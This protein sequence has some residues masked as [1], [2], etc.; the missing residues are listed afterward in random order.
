MSR[1]FHRPLR[2]ATVGLC[3]A[4]VGL[5]ALAGVLAFARVGPVQGLIFTVVGMVLVAAAVA[6]AR[7]YRWVLVVAV[8]VLGGQVGAVAG[9]AWELT[10]GV[11]DVKARELRALGFD[12]RLGVAVNLVY[13]AVACVLFGWFVARWYRDRRARSAG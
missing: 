11:A 3:L 9:T 8:I 13:S 6:V 5:C 12:P 4:G 2:L 7:G 10:H 1:V